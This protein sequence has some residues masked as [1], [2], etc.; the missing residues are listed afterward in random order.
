MQLG[1]YITL[2]QSESQA[3][4]HCNFNPHLHVLAA[5]GVFAT[6]GRS[7]H[8]RQCRM[9]FAGYMI[10]V[11]R[12]V[13]I[14]IPTHLRSYNNCVRWPTVRSKNPWHRSHIQ[15]LECSSLAAD[16]GERPWEISSEHDLEKHAQRVR[17]PR[18][19]KTG[20]APLRLSWTAVVKVI[21]SGAIHGDPAR[22]KPRK[23]ERVR[24][25]RQGARVGK[26]SYPSLWTRLIRKFYE[27]DPLVCPECRSNSC[28]PCA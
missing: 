25:P 6:D 9:K 19:I 3:A 27:A 8:C 20:R 21:N 23:Y 26:G 16:Q 2:M 7:P 13:Q 15:R 22:S 24:H 14:V 17:N 10:R 12:V 28:N 18:Q 1:F 5:D 11:R 4:E